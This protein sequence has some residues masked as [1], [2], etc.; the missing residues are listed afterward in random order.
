M[1]ICFSRLVGGWIFGLSVS[2]S[3]AGGLA[4]AGSYGLIE[5]G[6]RGSTLVLRADADASASVRDSS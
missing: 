4:A 5:A 6:D 1:V 3:K 2:V